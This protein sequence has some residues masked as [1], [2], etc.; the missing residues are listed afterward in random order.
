MEKYSIL[1]IDDNYNALKVV[2][3]YGEKTRGYDIKGASSLGEAAG[4]LTDQHFDLVTLDIELE[5]E[6]GLDDIKKIKSVYGG[7]IIFVSCLSDQDTISRGFNSGADDYICKPFNLEELFLRIERSILR[8][9]QYRKILIAEYH[10]D[11]FRNEIYYCNKQLDL[12]DLSVKVL[13]LL[14]KNK[15][16][17]L[18]RERI[19]KEVWGAN[20]DFSTR[21]VDTHISSIRKITND[22]RIKSIRG[23]GYVFVDSD[24]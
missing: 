8:F 11:E 21:V 4:L 20:Y 22:G 12:T 9:G 7:P 6:N 17:I 2:K 15:N 3:E 24:S 10:I 19:F 16:I 5:N 18:T 14:L 23:K 1:V 13:T